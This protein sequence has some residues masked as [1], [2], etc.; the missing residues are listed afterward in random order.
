MRIIGFFILA[1]LSA[2]MA[3]AGITPEEAAKITG[4][5]EETKL[6]YRLIGQDDCVNVSVQR[7]CDSEWVTCID[8]AWVVRYFLKEECPAAHEQLSLV[9]LVGAQDGRIISRYPEKPYF[10]DRRFCLEDFDCF[11]VPEAGCLNFLYARLEQG[12]DAQPG[13]VCRLQNCA[14]EE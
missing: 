7:P 9:F 6:F 14:P 4:K 11:D 8:D 10:E 5:L 13:C 12:G 3:R 2:G 1:F